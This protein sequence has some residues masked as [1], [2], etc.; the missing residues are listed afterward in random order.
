MFPHRDFYLTFRITYVA[1][2]VD[3]ARKEIDEVVRGFKMP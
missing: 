1:S 2:Q 3:R